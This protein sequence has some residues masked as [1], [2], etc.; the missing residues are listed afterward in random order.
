MMCGAV[1][2][3]TETRGLADHQAAQHERRTAE[4]TWVALVRIQTVVKISTMKSK[5]INCAHCCRVSSSYDMAYISMLPAN[6]GA[7]I[8][9]QQ[10]NDNLVM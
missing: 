3:G 9:E 7:A 6:Q 5:Y 4:Q 1:T 10:T 8:L 2:T